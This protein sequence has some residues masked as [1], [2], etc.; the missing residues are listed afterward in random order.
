MASHG[1]VHSRLMRID[2]FISFGVKTK[3]SLQRRIDPIFRGSV[4]DRFNVAYAWILLLRLQRGAERQPKLAYSHSNCIR[5]CRD[6]DIPPHAGAQTRCSALHHDLS[7]VH[8]A[9]LFAKSADLRDTRQ[10]RS[11][12]ALQLRFR[13]VHRFNFQTPRSSTPRGSGPIHDYRCRQN[14]CN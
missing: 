6:G 12:A 7:P 1:L 8:V 2:A 5:L 14:V 4:G 3:M 9:S 10:S 13:K 11:G